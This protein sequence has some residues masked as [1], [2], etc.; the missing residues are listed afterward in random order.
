[1]NRLMAWANW[2][3]LQGLYEVEA[4]EQ[5][6]FLS[7]GFL[8]PGFARAGKLIE[9]RFHPESGSEVHLLI[10]KDR[11]ILIGGVTDDTKVFLARYN[12]NGTID[13]TF[14]DDGLIIT[15]DIASFMGM[16][17][18]M[19]GKILVA[20]YSGIERL[21]SD[22]SLDESFGQGGVVVMPQGPN[23]MLAQPSGKIVLARNGLIVRMNPDGSPDTDFGWGTSYQTGYGEAY[24]GGEENRALQLRPYPDG[25]FVATVMLAGEDAEDWNF[26]NLKKFD[27]DGKYDEHFGFFGVHPSTDDMDI[28]DMEVRDDGKI[29][30]LANWGFDTD[31]NAIYVYNADGEPNW[32]FGERGLDVD[33]P[34]D[35]WDTTMALADDGDVLLFSWQPELV[36]VRLNRA[37]KLDKTFGKKGIAR[38]GMV[39]YNNTVRGAEDRDGTLIL[40][41]TISAESGTKLFLVRM[42]PEPSKKPGKHEK[43]KK[44]PRM[45]EDKSKVGAVFAK[46]FTTEAGLRWTGGENYFGNEPINVL[47]E[48]IASVWR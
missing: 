15:G 3:S 31:R 18:Q 47:G 4:L 14:S 10:Q 39:G 1:M 6:C 9:R 13:K 19:D 48:R 46:M 24:I 45:K 16:T 11:K 20:G 30:F 29:V 44:K 35:T 26:Y 38:T 12:P 5:R 7:A 17:L 41:G 33:A 37:G 43:P 23:D 32:R 8:D 27:V 40:A 28:T 25:G 2:R 42:D 22:G 34:L 21:N 36:A